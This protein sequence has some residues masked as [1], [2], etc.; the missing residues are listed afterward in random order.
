MKAFSMTVTTY[1]IVEV[2]IPAVSGI[3]LPQRSHHDHADKT[4]KEDD[5]HEGIEDGEPMD[6]HARKNGKDYM[7]VRGR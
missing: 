7:Y 3:V 2:I 4:N 6:L 1:Q 5:H